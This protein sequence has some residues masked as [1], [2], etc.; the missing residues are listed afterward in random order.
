MTKLIT[1]LSVSFKNYLLS[2]TTQTKHL[3]FLSILF[4]SSMGWGQTGPY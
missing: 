3:A 1:K 4:I 2:G